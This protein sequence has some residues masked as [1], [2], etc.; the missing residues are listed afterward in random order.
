MS[1][2][3]E[4]STRRALRMLH[5]ELDACS[6]CERMK[7]PVVHGPPV[8]SP[9]LLLGQAPGPHEG[10]LG[11]PFAWTAGRTMFR[12][13]EAALGLDEAAFRARVYMAAVARCFPGKASGGGDRRP[14]AQEIARCEPWLAREARILQP[15][16]VIAVGTLAIERVLGV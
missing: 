15:E 12:W 13:F 11:R 16:L 14:D 10:A 9:V 5:A 6:A 4:A 8:A 3:V 7:G 1:V 2:L